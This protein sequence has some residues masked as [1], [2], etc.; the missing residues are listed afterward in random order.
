MKILLDWGI[1]VVLWL[2]Q[3]HPALDSIFKGFSFLGEEDF[4][5][6]MM[7][8]IYWC[9]DRAN[10]VRLSVFYLINVWLNSVAKL[11]AD[12]PRPF[13]YDTRVLK[14]DDPGGK[15]FPSGHTQSAV[16]VWGFLGYTFKKRWLWVL[17]GI[18]M[19]CIPISRLYLGV[20]FP[21]DLLGGYVIGAVLLWLYIQFGQR[22]ETWVGRLSLVGQIAL[23]VGIA[24]LLYLLRPGPDE[25]IASAAGILLGAGVGVAVERKH[26]RFD[27][28]GNWLQLVLRLLIGLAGLM[29]LRYGLKAAFG[30]MEPQLLFRFTRYAVMGVWFAWLAPWLFVRLRLAKKEA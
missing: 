13:E 29:I 12:Q 7:P 3:F 23:A 22:L 28:Q 19:V 30:T 26:V 15:G 25:A 21:T 24:I 18:L 9:V 10:G 14:L 20:H 2:Q 17:A 27:S 6:V 16:V 1:E 4:F 5:M 11:I 8:L